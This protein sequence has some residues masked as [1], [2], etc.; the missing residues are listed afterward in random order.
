MGI[1]SEDESL[2]SA[3][4]EFYNDLWAGDFVGNP[5]EV[6]YH[7]GPADGATVGIGSTTVGY[8]VE[9]TD[10]QEAGTDYTANLT[11]VATPTF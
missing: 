11:Y 9:I 1:T 10:F 8:Q 2:S 6:M 4:V 7:D 3:G 5:R